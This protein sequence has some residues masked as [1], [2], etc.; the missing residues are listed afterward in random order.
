MP[1]VTIV[2][3]TT[4]RYG[5]PI[6][7]GD[8][9]PMVRPRDSHDLRLVSATLAAAP[10]ARLRWK[11]GVFGTSIA[12]ASFADESEILEFVSTIEVEHY[13]AAPLDVASLI[14]PYAETHPFAYAAEEADDLAPYL[15]RHDSD[16]NRTVDLWAK[17]FRRAEGPTRTADLLVAITRAIRADFAYE[18]R[19][20]EGTRPAPETLA[21]RRGACRDF[22]LL[23]MEACRSLGLAAR[24]VSGYLYDDRLIGS[25]NPMVGGGATHAWCEVYLPGA[26]WVEFDPTNGLLA[27]RNLIR[28]AVTRT[29]EQ[30]APISGTFFG[31]A[32]DFRGLEVAVD[33][34]VAALPGEIVQPISATGKGGQSAPA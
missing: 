8:H 16:P 34:T 33:V 28:V 3:R 22:A 24:F 7:F 32:A 9:R 15:R 12:I 6:R 5:R 29:P 14:E 17:S 26:G 27:G 20:E 2:H 1:R 10:P 31:E 18:A 4:Y 25:E 19:E 11:H 21:K 30:A 13:P 23:M